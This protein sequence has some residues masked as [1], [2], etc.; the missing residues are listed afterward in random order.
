MASGMQHKNAISTA[1]EGLIQAQLELY[2]HS[3]GYVKSAALRAAAELGIPD[4]IHR[5]GGVATLSDIAT[6]T[7]IHPSKYSHLRRLMHTLTVTGIFSVEG[8]D[9]DAGY[10]LTLVSSVLVEGGESM[11]NLSPMVPLL[12]E[13]LKLTMLFDIKV[14]FTDEQA[15]AMTLFEVA[16]GCT[17][18]EM[19]AKKGT[20][21]I[22]QAAMVADTNLVMEVVLKEHMG[23]FKGV[24]SLVDA[25]GAHGAAAAAISK[26]LPH[27]KCTVLD[28]P[29]VIAGAPTSRDVQFVAGDVFEYIPPADAILLKWILCIWRDEDAVKV[30]RR[31]KEAIPAG[32][33][34]II[35]DG[36]VDSGASQNVILKETQVLFDIMMMGIDGVER[37]EQQWKKM[38]VEAGFGD[39][40][41]SPVGHRSI[42]EVYP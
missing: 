8:Y 12:V 34:V 5:H 9:D 26:A 30:L 23:I 25:G 40:K 20:G 13:L 29:H 4:A 41:I 17:P 24:N 14:W 39:Y 37:D 2:H 16:H 3:L 7:G 28:L 42:I 6:E 32:G 11:C 36:V 27:V 1:T 10:K 38:F 35:F 33:K 18:S 31:C 15:S 21:G 22:F 19:K